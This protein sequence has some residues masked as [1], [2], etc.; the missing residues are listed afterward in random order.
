[1]KS[2]GVTFNA[3]NLKLWECCGKYNAIGVPFCSLCGKERPDNSYSGTPYTKPERR[4]QDALGSEIAL[5]ETLQDFTGRNLCVTIE[6]HSPRLLDDD[7]FIGGCKQLRDAIAEVLGRKGDSEA[8][9]LKF[10]YL[11][12][13]SK[14]KKTVIKTAGNKISG[15]L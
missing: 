7:N 8:D 1:M 6:R 2:K 10:E 14:I 12:V 11:Q 4:K 3:N 15:I 13:K 9:G 5:E